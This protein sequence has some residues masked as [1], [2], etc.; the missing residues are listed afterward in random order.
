MGEISN[1]ISALQNQR[2]SMVV[3]YEKRAAPALD[4]RHPNYRD[5][6]ESNRNHKLLIRLFSPLK[7]P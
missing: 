4:M 2:G 6:K 3:L 1:E 7:I 5:H